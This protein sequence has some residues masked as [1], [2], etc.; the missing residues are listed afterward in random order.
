MQIL[1]ILDQ[2]GV[3]VVGKGFLKGFFNFGG[4]GGFFKGIFELSFCKGFAVGK[5]GGYRCKEKASGLFVDRKFEKG[6]A[7]NYFCVPNVRETVFLRT[8]EPRTDIFC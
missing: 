1:N 3:C 8:V 2:I 5:T 6:S 7:T 4:G